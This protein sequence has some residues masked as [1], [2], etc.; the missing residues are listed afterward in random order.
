[1]RFGDSLNRLDDF[2]TVEKGG[3]ICVKKLGI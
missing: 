3:D 2:V 1:M